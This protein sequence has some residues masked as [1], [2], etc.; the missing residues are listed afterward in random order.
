MA[1]HIERRKFLATLGGAAAAWPLAAR[2][3]QPAMPVI[4]F[5]GSESSESEAF[6]VAAVRK[7]LSEAGYVESDGS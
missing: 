5:L 4:G 6:R 2:A 3:Q 7:R 1:S